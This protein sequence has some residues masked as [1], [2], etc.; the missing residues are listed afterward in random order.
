MSESIDFEEAYF[1]DVTK[2]GISI[3]AS[4]RIGDEFEGLLANVDTG[5]TYCIF[6][7]LHGE[8]LGIDIESG[9]PIEMGTVT[10][11]FRAYGHEM[12]MNILGIESIAT[13]YFAESELFDRNVLG[14]IGWLDQLKL[15]IVEHDGKLLLSRY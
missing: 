14:R 1:Y 2:V 5:S 8:A 3:P 10:G 9:L 15:G 4:L 6:E 12:T 13:V 7:R 11:S